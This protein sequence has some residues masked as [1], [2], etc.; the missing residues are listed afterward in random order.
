MSELDHELIAISITPV[1]DSLQ[2]GDD[3]RLERTMKS[4]SRKRKVSLLGWMT[5]DGN[6]EEAR[7]FSCLKA[8]VDVLLTVFFVCCCCCC[9]CCSSVAAEK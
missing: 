4:V 8:V 6:V 9:C 1:G 3:F 7:L 5:E 2:R